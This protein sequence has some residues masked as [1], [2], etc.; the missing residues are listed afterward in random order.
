MAYFLLLL[1]ALSISQVYSFCR[2]VPT[3]GMTSTS[4]EIEVSQIIY[5]P[6]ELIVAI[7]TVPPA[8]TSF[9]N[10]LISRKIAEIIQQVYYYLLLLFFILFRKDCQK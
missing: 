5:D 8:R 3:T 6:L 7:R 1:I 4:I 10:D 9:Q 2:E